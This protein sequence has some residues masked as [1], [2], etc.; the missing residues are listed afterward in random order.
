MTSPICIIR[1]IYRSIRCRRWVSGCEMETAAYR[2]PP[3][4]H[5]L[6]C[7]TCGKDSFAWAWEGIEDQK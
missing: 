1:T 7:R 6:K 5:A 3:N 4:V 2:T